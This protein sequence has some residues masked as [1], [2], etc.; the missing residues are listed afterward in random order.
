MVQGCCGALD[1]PASRADA[2]GWVWPDQKRI[3]SKERKQATIRCIMSLCDRQALKP[4]VERTVPERVVISVDLRPDQMMTVQDVFEHVLDVFR[5]VAASTPDVQDEVNWRFVSAT[6]NSPFTVTAEAVAARPDVQI[7]PIARRQKS[8]F[9]KNYT[10]LSLG[11]LPSDWATSKTRAIINNILRHNI[12]QINKTT[13]DVNV[14]P[15]EKPISITRIEADIAVAAIANIQ[16]HQPPKT[17]NQ[18]GSIE[19]RLI[20]I[21]KYYNKPAIQIVE[22][23]T[24]DEIWCIVPEKF[25]RQISDSASIEDVWKGSRVIVKGQIVFG[26]NGN[27]SSVIATDIRR[28]EAKIISDNQIVD[29]EFTSGL[30]VPEYLDRL[31]DGNFG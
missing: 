24:G 2:E 27:V 30:P 8:A 26:V 20:Q 9:R 1:R 4:L 17:K 13:I 3:H 6:M 11:L 29:R 25:E 12:N 19:G 10:Q 5:L 7:E 16:P 23:R 21:N 22:R 18:I 15:G 28:I 14:E 31:W